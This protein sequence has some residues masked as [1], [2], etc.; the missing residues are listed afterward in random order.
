MEIPENEETVKAS[1]RYNVVIKKNETI[2]SHFNQ[3]QRMRGKL[4]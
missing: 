4:C 2:L 1:V 3:K